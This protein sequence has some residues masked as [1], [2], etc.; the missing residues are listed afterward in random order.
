VRFIPQGP[1]FEP[2]FVGGG[3]HSL[4]KKLVALAHGSGICAFPNPP[5][6]RM[7]RDIRMTPAIFSKGNKKSHVNKFLQALYSRQKLLIPQNSMLVEIKRF[8][9]KQTL[10]TMVDWKKILS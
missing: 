6:S 7:L 1:G 4:R 2:T 8:G 10:S 9:L 3:Q 5:T